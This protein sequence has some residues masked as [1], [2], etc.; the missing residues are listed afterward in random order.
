MKRVLLIRSLRD[1]ELLLAGCAT[2]AFAFT[3]LRIWVASHIQVDAFVKFFS[4]SFK[5][6]QEL[7]PVPVADLASPLGRVAFSFEEFGLVLLLGLW[8]VARGSDC[9]AGRIGAGTMEMLLA[10]PVRRFTLVSTHTLVTLLGVIGI[11]SAAW[12][13]V[14]AGLRFSK[15]EPPPTLA[16]VTPAVLNFISLGVFVAGAATIASALCRTRSAAVGAVVGFYIVEIAIMVVARLADQFG[17]MGWLTIFSAY[18]PTM[19]TLS[20]QRDPAA[21]WTLLWQYNG[22]L[23]GLGALL[24]AG[25]AAIFCHRD[26]PAPL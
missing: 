2:L 25:S 14:A 18:E 1:S 23:V 5:M 17:W 19:L 20:V 4:E 6:L 16:T 8:T 9:L 13:G 12:A 15:F 3:W 21:G 11:A 26:V 24:L 22:C 7:L 10:Q